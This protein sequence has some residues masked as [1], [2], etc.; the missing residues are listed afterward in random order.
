MPR[1]RNHG[2]RKRCTCARSKWP[3]CPHGWHVNFGWKGVKYRIS[4]DRDCGRHIAGKTEAGAQADRIRS[5]IRDG[6]YSP[7][8]D[9][10]AST[11]NLTLEA[12]ADVFIE[13][14]SK[15]RQKITWKN[16]LGMVQKISEFRCRKGSRLGVMAIGSI[17]EDDIEEFMS[18]L[19]VLGRAA[20]TRN[21][22]LQIMKA[23]SNWGVRK[24]YLDRPWIGPLCDLKRDRIARRHRRLEP[25]EEEQL[26]AVASSR[27]Y[28]LVVA[29][30]ETGCRQGE[31]L[32]LQWCDVDLDRRELR[33]QARNA[34]DREDRHIPIST[35]LMAVLEMARHDPAG[36]AFG[37]DAYVFGDEV[38]G[39]VQSP[40]KAGSSHKCMHGFG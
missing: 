12:Y 24:G 38:G 9:G 35:R 19:R 2:L 34:K 7:G 18:H 27:L 23:M 14:Y 29:A 40:K 20:S 6:K 5:E 13:R 37:R 10:A 30:L 15:A 1:H 8:H 26:L 3:K 28:R 31:L 16:D 33:I 39:R 17:T 36:R 32:S 11:E 25:A 4:L 22:Y 21:Q